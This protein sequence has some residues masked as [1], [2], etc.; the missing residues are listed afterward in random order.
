MCDV[1]WDSDGPA[2]YSRTARRARKQHV[3][4]A[5]A[6]KIQPGEKY[7]V[8]AFAAERGDK[9]ESQKC[10]MACEAIRDAFMEVH[11]SGP[12]ASYTRSALRHCIE[13]EP[14]SAE[15]WQPMLDAMDARRKAAA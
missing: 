6:G 15:T 13:E 2:F 11:D 12:F 7:V 10:C 9:A 3:C 4:D 5:C 1:G 14:A 8:E